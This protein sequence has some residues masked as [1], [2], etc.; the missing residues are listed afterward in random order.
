MTHVE[1]PRTLSFEELTIWRTEL[2]DVKFAV[3]PPDNT[4]PNPL[5]TDD[6]LFVSVL[7][8]GAV[9]ALQ[10]D[11]GRMIWRRELEK[12]SGSAVYLHSGRLFANSSH[13]LYALRPDSG[14]TLWS[15]CPYG[16]EGEW[17]YSSPT[18]YQDKLYIGD[19]KGFLH[20]LDSG[21]GETIWSKC[22][23][24]EGNPSVNSTPA[25]VNGLVI[26]PTN[27]KV[28][29]AYDAITGEDAWEQSVD[30]ASTFGPL[31]HNGLLAV[32]TVE[33][34]YL[35]DSADGQVRQHFQWKGDNIDFAESTRRDL[36]ILLRGTSPSKDHSEIV[37]LNELGIHR[38]GSLTGN[39]LRF[40]HSIEKELLYAS[41]FHGVDLFRPDTGE[42]LCKLTTTEESG[43]T[44]L[45]DIKE[46]MIYALTGEGSVHALRHPDLG[47]Q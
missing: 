43:D 29:V 33:S 6:K 25:I 22:T 20:C 1:K 46:N 35:L 47:A 11:S 37:F 42:V 2:P 44:A 9:C 21:T 24:R 27:A 38:T 4:R 18:V 19:R 16:T 40:R 32:V 23:N 3:Q 39:C 30:R 31:L 7:F 34:L 26:V 14:E 36:V 45:V 17:I 28:V 15:F 8:P 13:T 41:H 12:F 10:R 5:A